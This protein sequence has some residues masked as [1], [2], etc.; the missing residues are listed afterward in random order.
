[1]A[2]CV[3][4]VVVTVALVPA[5]AEVGARALAMGGA[6]TG[7]ADDVTATYWNPAA[8]VDL[9][10]NRLTYMRGPGEQLGTQ[11]YL[12][13]AF[14]YGERSAVGLSYLDT[15]LMPDLH[16][17]QM[18]ASWAQH[19]Y[20]LSYA[21]KASN[22]TYIRANLRRVNDLLDVTLDGSPTGISADTDSGVDLALYHHAGDRVTVGLLAQNINRPSTRVRFREVN[23]GEAECFANYRPGIAVRI[24]EGTIVSAELYDALNR[25]DSRA[26]RLGIERTFPDERLA[27]RAGR[28][29]AG[30]VSALTFGAGVYGKT[31]AMDI[32]YLG[33]ELGNAWVFSVSSRF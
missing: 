10:T 26:L 24:Q 22:N 27:L 30:R 31:W 3:P 7:L 9:D 28:Y 1:V 21:L 19:W 20:W 13:F 2:L 4:L 5:N 15:Q 33:V 29:A 25:G 14:Q 12:A 6:F 16:T 23:Y 11:N 32:A 8:L 17:A 18:S